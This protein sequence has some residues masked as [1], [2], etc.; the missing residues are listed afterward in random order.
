MR[1]HLFL[2]L[3]GLFVSA[4]S[5][6]YEMP[7]SSVTEA[8][9]IIVNGFLNP[10][11][12][13]RIRLHRLTRSGGK[14]TVA[15]LSGARIVLKENETTLFDG[16][17]ADS[18]LL[19]PQ[20]PIVGAS[21]S[22]EVSYAGLPVAKAQT[23][24]PQAIR[25]TAAFSSEEKYGRLVRLKAFDLARLADESL[26]V[27]VYR[28]HQDTIIDQYPE[29]YAN[30]A[31]IDRT[32]RQVGV[33]VVNELVGAMYYIGFLRVKH[34]NLSALTELVFTPS[35]ASAGTDTVPKPDPDRIRVRLITATPEYDRYNKSLYE[36]KHMIISE[37]DISSVFYKPQ[38]VYTN[39]SD[40]LGIFAGV[41]EADYIFDLP[42]RKKFIP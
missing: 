35:Y 9:R 25:C 20:H 11:D 10:S 17:C 12:S 32:N 23:R 18:V 4:C 19:L 22:L 42:K 5:V 14:Y 36:Q 15:A 30:N 27:T 6:N 31:L 28:Q 40:G 24:I 13:I 7:P 16:V 8:D 39:I 3:I 38:A 1:K 21:Y 37:D 2:C 26:W 29:I 33:G 34:K 41:N